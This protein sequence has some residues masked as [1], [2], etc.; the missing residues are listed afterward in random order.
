[1]KGDTDVIYFLSD[2]R[3]ATKTTREDEEEGKL[4]LIYMLLLWQ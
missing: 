3:S 4:F 2:V 1:M